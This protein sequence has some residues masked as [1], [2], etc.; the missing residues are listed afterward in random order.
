MNKQSIPLPQA[1]WAGKDR[2]HPCLRP[3]DLFQCKNH[4]PAL[5]P[6]L[7]CVPSPLPLQSEPASPTCRV[8]GE[9][10]TWKSQPWMHK[11]EVGLTLAKETSNLLLC[12]AQTKSCCLGTCSCVTVPFTSFHINVFAL[13]RADFNMVQQ[14]THMHLAFQWVLR[15]LPGAAGKLDFFFDAT[16][17]MPWRQV[18]VWLWEML[19]YLGLPLRRVLHIVGGISRTRDTP[20]HL[21]CTATSSASCSQPLLGGLSLLPPLPTSDK[22]ALLH[23]KGKSACHLLAFPW[24]SL[25]SCSGYPLSLPGEDWLTIKYRNRSTCREG[26]WFPPCSVPSS[27]EEFLVCSASLWRQTTSHQFQQDLP[28]LKGVPSPWWN[29]FPAGISRETS[30]RNIAN[31]SAVI[32]FINC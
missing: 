18:L 1:G 6:N 30:I 27:P 5:R 8:P 14:G 23:L 22:Q 16:A 12:A 11:L 21:S 19:G 17:G 25:D 20:A 10:A 2:T 13:S 3:L 28:Y 9:P 15:A 29:Q 4:T 32:H 26:A 31:A 24:V 7:L